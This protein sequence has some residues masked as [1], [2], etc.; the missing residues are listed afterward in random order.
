MSATV[1]AA[2]DF[3]GWMARSLDRR[4]TLVLTDGARKWLADEGF[5]PEFGARPLKR[6]LQ[7]RV[8]DP[9]ALKILSGEFKTGDRIEIDAGKDGLV[10]RS[11]GKGAAVS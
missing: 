1:G 5:D 10:F 2:H 9:L 7:R 3:I 8:Q 4:V 6:T 11:T